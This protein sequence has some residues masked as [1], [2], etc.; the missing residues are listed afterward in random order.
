MTAAG[1]AIRRDTATGSH[2]TDMPGQ[3]LR[4]TAYAGGYYLSAAKIMPGLSSRHRPHLVG[5]AG[6]RW[7]G[8]R[9]PEPGVNNDRG[10]R[11]HQTVRRQNSSGRPDVHRATG[12]GSPGFLGP[13]GAVKS[14]TMRMILGLDAPTSGAVTVNGKHYAEHTAPLHEVLARCWRPRRL[15]SGRS[16]LL[17]PAVARADHPAFRAGR[18]D[19]VID[20]VGLRD[21]A[22]RRVGRLLVRHWASGSAW[23]PR[24][25]ATRPPSCWTSRSTGWTRRASSGSGRCC[26]RWPP[27]GAPCRVV[28]LMS[29]MGR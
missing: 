21:V 24:C 4:R 28:A 25:S 10:A 20:M 13:N 17:P 29:E 2:T 22:R 8:Y 27:R 14:T 26:A 5:C 1:A 6:C 23:P 12:V 3:Y 7:W 11:R 16:A 9:R 19:E 15:H 18:V